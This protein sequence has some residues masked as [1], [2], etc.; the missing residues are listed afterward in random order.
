MIGMPIL[1][2]VLFLNMQKLTMLKYNGEVSL[3]MEDK[4]IMLYSTLIQQVT[5]LVQSILSTIF[6]QYPELILIQIKSASFILLLLTQ[7][8]AFQGL[9]L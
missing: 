1:W 5:M 3:I 7:Q 9:K 2:L 6:Y 8:V 4:C